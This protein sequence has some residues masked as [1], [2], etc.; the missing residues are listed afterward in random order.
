MAFGTTRVATW[1][2]SPR[3]GFN[4]WHKER[5][6]AVQFRHLEPSDFF[7]Q[8]LGMLHKRGTLSLVGLP[9]GE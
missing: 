7:N 9:H 8:A 1:S 5:P 3:R 2:A 6:N 4:Y